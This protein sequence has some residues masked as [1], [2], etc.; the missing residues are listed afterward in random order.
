M[1]VGVY[2]MINLPSVPVTLLNVATT[3]L[4]T[5]ISVVTG[6]PAIIASFSV[7]FNVTVAVNSSLA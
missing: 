5:I 4:F 2:A 1:F 6:A 3:L 7:S